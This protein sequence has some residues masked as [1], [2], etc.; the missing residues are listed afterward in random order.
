M[1]K[2]VYKHDKESSVH[3]R[4]TESKIKFSEICNRVI[5]DHVRVMLFILDISV[6]FN[7][8]LSRFLSA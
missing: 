6:A 4:L 2:C 8:L 3:L 7:I 5:V 1:V